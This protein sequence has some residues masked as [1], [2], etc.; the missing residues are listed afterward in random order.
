MSN[1]MRPPQREGSPLGGNPMSK[2][3]RPYQISALRASVSDRQQGIS[4]QLICMSTGLG[5][6]AIIANIPGYHG[7]AAG[8]QMVFLVDREEL[9][10][11]SRD[12]LIE[13]NPTRHVGAEKAN[14]LYSNSA[15]DLIVLSIQSMTP[16]RLQ[17]INPN[18]VRIV[19]VD[20]ADIAVNHKRYDEILRYFRVHKDY[21]NAD[22][23]KLLIGVTATPN[24]HDG[25]GLERHYEKI[26]FSMGLRES[27]EQGWLCEPISY[28]SVTRTDLSG[29]KTAG[30]DFQP[31]AL[32]SA[33][34]T[35]ERNLQI[36]QEYTRHGEGLPLIAFTEGISHSTHLAEA[37]R[38]RGINVYPVSSKTPERERRKLVR[39]MRERAIDGLASCAVLQRGFDSPVAS[40]ALMARP[41]KS[42][43]LYTQS[44]GRVLRPYP[45]PEELAVMRRLNSEPPWVKKHAVVID[46]MDNMG[47]HSLVSLP[48]LFGLRADFDSKGESVVRAAK[49]MEL[50]A[51]EKPG[52]NPFDYA[53]IE[54]AET[55]STR[56][57]LLRAPT[58]SPM[59]RKFSS[60]AWLELS[61]GVAALATDKSLLIVKQNLLGRFEVYES[62][63]GREVFRY[64][65][66]SP[67][68]AFAEADKWVPKEQLTLM[69]A[70]ASWHKD[71]P[72][73]KQSKQVYQN[74]PTVKRSFPDLSA[75]HTYVIAEHGK[76]NT[77]YSKGGMSL[78]ISGLIQANPKL[79][80]RFHY[81]KKKR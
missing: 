39:L 47:R 79:Q 48:T 26:T 9:V 54:A 31:S 68:A 52:F 46:F 21:P 66:P 58:L 55:T 61:P 62:K 49:Q 27:I 1:G 63:K 45:A 70:N 33:I 32:A 25:I 24:R 17:S 7:L 22:A 28:R 29:I 74:D 4:R 53:S 60:L 3:L 51:E 10:F 12:S 77:Q 69:K 2:V 56:I 73:E 67:A 5:K 44:I 40:C 34:D 57:D 76:G 59:A 35:P 6:T 19:A 41:T 8:E 37:F 14:E 71:E 42:Q 38:S 15:D 65:S 23:T 11:Q 80:S 64:S 81:G 50:L 75:Y 20:E 43:T 16:E 78:R 36:V 30:G 13:W 18:R 72:T